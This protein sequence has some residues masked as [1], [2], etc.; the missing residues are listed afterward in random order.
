[1][2]YCNE[3]SL[4]V[5]YSYSYSIVQLKEL[6]NAVLSTINRSWSILEIVSFCQL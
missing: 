5:H 3:K 2:I 1:M 6:N 4:S